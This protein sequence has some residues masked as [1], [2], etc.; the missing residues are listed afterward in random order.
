[1]HINMGYDGRYSATNIGTISFQRDFGSPLT[2]KDD[3][4]I[5]GLKKNLVSFAM[6]EDHGYDVIFS[7]G[8]AFLHHIASGCMI[9]KALWCK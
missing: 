1:M 4:Y 6:S 5:S 2:L 9:F 7:K 8:K 3:M